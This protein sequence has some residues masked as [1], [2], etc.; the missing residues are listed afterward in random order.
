MCPKTFYNSRAA[1]IVNAAVVIAPRSSARR[2]LAASTASTLVGEMG[3]GAVPK[4]A[5]A[6]E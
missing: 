2:G 6:A 5:V 3:N 1:P 4:Q